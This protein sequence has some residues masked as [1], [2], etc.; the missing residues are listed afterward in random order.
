[1]ASPIPHPLPP[2]VPS[3]AF[4]TSLVAAGLL[5]AGCAT[6][7]DRLPVLGPASDVP[8]AFLVVTPDGPVA[9]SDEGA[10]RS[11]LVDPRDGTRLTM[12]RST[13]TVADYRVPAGRY[14]VPDG[15]LLR[16]ECA[17]GRPVGMVAR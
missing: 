12:A 4:R 8:E 11:P 10:C 1:M 17:T 3:R 15:R 2:P 13:G 16:V 7:T 14:G 5:A 6:S 9:A